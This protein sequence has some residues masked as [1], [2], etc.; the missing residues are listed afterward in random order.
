MPWLPVSELS[1]Y[2]LSLLSLLSSSLPPFLSIYLLPYLLS[3]FLPSFLPSLL[4]SVLLQYFLPLYLPSSSYLP[5]NPSLFLSYNL[6]LQCWQLHPDG[7]PSARDLITTFAPAS[8]NTDSLHS[9][10]SG[11]SR[12]TFATFIGHTNLSFLISPRFTWDL[13]PQKKTQ[14]TQ[15]NGCSVC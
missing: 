10:S 11:N 2:S 4:L 8:D 7:R 14:H 3:F 13:L 15:F 9:Q 5:S 6:M 12:V 1:W